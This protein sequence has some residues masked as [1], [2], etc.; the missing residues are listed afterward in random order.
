MNYDG[1][2]PSLTKSPSP[3]WN[4][5]FADHLANYYTVTYELL[6]SI[7][8]HFHAMDCKDMFYTNNSHINDFDFYYMFF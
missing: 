6:S 1:I 2:T 4:M 8:I 5:S 7:A 3:L